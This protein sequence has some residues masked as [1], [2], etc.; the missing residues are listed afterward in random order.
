M[1]LEKRVDKIEQEV[2]EGRLDIIGILTRL[3]VAES[4]ISDIKEDLSSIKQN[5]T[6][7]IR[8]IMGA[9]ILAV[10]GFIITTNGGK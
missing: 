8:L 4:N 3:A 1:E 9:I 6:W 5:T 2:K 7:I 10:L